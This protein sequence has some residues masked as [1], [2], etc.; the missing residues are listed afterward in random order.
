MSAWAQL[1]ELKRGEEEVK[2]LDALMLK[3]SKYVNTVSQWGEKSLDACEGVPDFFRKLLPPLRNLSSRMLGSGLESAK[4][5][6]F[7]QRPDIEKMQAVVENKFPSHGSYVAGVK[8]F[9]LNVGHLSKVLFQL[10][11]LI[12]NVEKQQIPSAEQTAEQYHAAVA[13]FRLNPDLLAATGQ[14]G[15]VDNAFNDFKSSLEDLLETCN[16]NLEKILEASAAW[17]AALM[18]ELL[19]LPNFEADMDT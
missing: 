10:D 15:K 2:D 5:K 1:R 16:M 12:L 14:Q 11:C 13:A 9:L 3:L 18:E 19:A 4:A 17:N 8:D 7:E 6:V